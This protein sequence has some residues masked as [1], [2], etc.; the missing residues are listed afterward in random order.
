MKSSIAPVMRRVVAVATIATL[1]ACASQNTLPRSASGNAGGLRTS[2][3]PG[4]TPGFF[5]G[6]YIKHIVIIVQENRSFDNLFYGFPGADYATTGLDSS[7]NTVTLAP[8]PFEGVYDP[9]HA[10]FCWTPEY[11]NGQM[12]GFD[13]ESPD[14]SDVDYDYA[15]VPNAETLPYF[16][17]ATQYTL[18]DRMFQTD[19]TS[20][21]PS[22]QFLI[23]G[24]SPY[25]FGSPSNST[26]WGC[27]APAGTTVNGIDPNGNATPNVFPCFDYMTIGDL[28]DRANHT[29]RVYT[30]PIGLPDGLLDGF[31]AIRHIRFGPDWN[32]TYDAP[33]TNILTEAP[34]GMLADLTYVYPQDENSDHAEGGTATG[35]S[36]VANVI[37]AVGESGYWSS[38]AI[39]VTW[40]D[41]GG[42][43]DHVAPKEYDVYGLGFRV[44]LLVVS[45]YAKKGY[46]SH[47]QH[48]FGSIL[49]FSEETFGLGSLGTTDV[50]ADDLADCFDFTQ[51]PGTFVPIEAKIKPGYYIAHAKDPDHPDY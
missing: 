45:P 36:W 38:T 12:N 49:R 37:N 26:F 14:S 6:N 27:D 25:A 2:T 47:V 19:H 51:T 8:T 30:P 10:S 43:Y 3:L 48:E 44:P 22:H 5:P 28:L 20:S 13:Q 16:N 11:N 7:N 24:Q 15:Y 29:W 40:D 31:D 35:P 46:I 42:W 41:W 23:A 21:F 34:T 39:F 1:G 4:A 17:I 33:E 9:C 32:T 18:A 50:R